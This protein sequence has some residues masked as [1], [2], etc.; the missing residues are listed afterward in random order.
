[1]PGSVILRLLMSNPCIRCGK[2]RIDGKS[3][4]SKSGNVEITHTQTI[5][6]DSACQRIVDKG[7]ADR[8]E[9]AD[10]ILRKKDEAKLARAKLLAVS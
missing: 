9:K 8:K 1:M 2:P 6:P 3:W 7:I 4:K 10:M 5:C